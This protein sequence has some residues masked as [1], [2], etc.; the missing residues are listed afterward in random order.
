MLINKTY[1]SILE[2]E[3]FNYLKKVNK[4]LFLLINDGYFIFIPFKLDK[5]NLI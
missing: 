1:H 5:N 3:K 2:L 4:K